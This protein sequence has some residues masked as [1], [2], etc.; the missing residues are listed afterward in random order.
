MIGISLPNAFGC[1]NVQIMT[2][3]RYL[4]E[5]VYT[6]DNRHCVPPKHNY[7]YNNNNKTISKTKLRA[8]HL[9]P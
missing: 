1:S 8:R 5:L 2:F 9:I 4:N 7:N 6:K 3:S